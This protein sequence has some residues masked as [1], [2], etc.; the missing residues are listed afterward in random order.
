MP[1]Y[2]LHYFNVKGAAEPIRLIFAQ[3]GV[4][5]ED[6]RLSQ[7]EWAEFKPKTPYSVMPV[8][9]VDGKNLSEVEP[10]RILLD[11]A[12]RRRMLSGNSFKTL[13]TASLHS[14]PCSGS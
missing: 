2:K 12:S 9:D 8:L 1:T 14:D 6:V 11:E 13:D 4:K 7:E 3:A 5:Y 10:S